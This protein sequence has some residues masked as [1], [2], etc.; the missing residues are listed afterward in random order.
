MRCHPAL[1]TRC[2]LTV[3][4][5]LLT[6]TFGDTFAASSTQGAS[7]CPSSTQVPSGKRPAGSETKSSAVCSGKL[8]LISLPRAPDLGRV[9]L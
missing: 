2:N 3:T 8:S 9:P 6:L 1:T 4:P 7:S 5:I